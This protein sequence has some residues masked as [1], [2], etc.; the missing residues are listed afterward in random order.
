[1]CSKSCSSVENRRQQLHQLFAMYS[2]CCC[3][4]SVRWSFCGN[5]VKIS[6]VSRRIIIYRRR[7]RVVGRYLPDQTSRL[8]F[9]RKTFPFVYKRRTRQQND[10][11]TSSTVLSSSSRYLPITKTNALSYVII[12]FSSYFTIF[13]CNF[14]RSTQ[15]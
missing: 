4:F 12:T 9:F 11:P 13:R 7:G 15:S 5:N 2:F 3:G 6:Q 10:T 14:Q 1:M 8:R